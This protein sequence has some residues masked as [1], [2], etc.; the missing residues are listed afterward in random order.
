MAGEFVPPIP[1]PEMIEL[2]T[3][4]AAGILGG[5]FGRLAGFVDELDYHE[6]SLV[7]FLALELAGVY[8]VSLNLDRGDYFRIAAD[9]SFM[10]GA[11]V[12]FFGFRKCSP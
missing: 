9:I 1:T 10:A 12:G 2:G 8:A 7:F 5:L 3:V 6:I 11:A 4:V